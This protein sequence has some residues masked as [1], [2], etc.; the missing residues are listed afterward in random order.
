MATGGRYGVEMRAALPADAAEIAG[1]LAGTERPAD[2][3]QVAARLDTVLH[4]PS[5]ASLVATGWNGAVIGLAVLHWHPVLRADR[6]L[7]RLT[8]LIVAGEE[9]R[10]GVGRLL[11]KAASQAARQAGCDL[12][13]AEEGDAPGFFQALGFQP[14]AMGVV[15]ALRKRSGDG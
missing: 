14:G 15:R 3:R 8:A 1:L 4:D 12:L 2:V 6:P 11:I 10:R 13:L 9:R 7:A 5:G